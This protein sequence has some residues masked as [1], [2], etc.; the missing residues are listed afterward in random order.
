M[1]REGRWSE[2]IAVGSLNLV[3]KLRITKGFLD[4]ALIQRNSKS[5]KSKIDRVKLTDPN[6]TGEMKR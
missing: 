3:A 2:A 6:L 4:S 1:V 5:K